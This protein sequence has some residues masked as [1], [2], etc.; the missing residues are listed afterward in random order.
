MNRKL[1][2]A[3][4]DLAQKR[5]AQKEA[6]RA[7]AAAGATTPS[8][9]EAARI[10]ARQLEQA[11]VFDLPAPP[12]KAS[13]KANLPQLPIAEDALSKP[14]MFC[15]VTIFEGVTELGNPTWLEPVGSGDHGVNH[16]LLC[17]EGAAAKAYFARQKR[18]R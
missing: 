18:R 9:A 16:W 2:N 10:A 13:P 8:A 14:C 12:P 7:E 17:A 5:E 15:G 11:S 1:L 3:I 6:A 4:D